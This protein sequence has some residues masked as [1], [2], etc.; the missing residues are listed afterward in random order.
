MGRVNEVNSYSK[1]EQ[2]KGHQKEKKLPKYQ[3]KKPK[4]KKKQRGIPL[5]GKRGKITTAEYNKALQHGDYCLVCQTTIG[6]EAHHVKFKSNSG[7]GKARNVRFL[8]GEH[9]RGKNGP[10]H[11]ETFRRELEALHEKEF[12]PLYWSDEYDLYN[13]N[14]IPNTTKKAYEKYMQSW[15]GV[16]Y[17]L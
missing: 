2:L 15:D 17:E 10:H 5:A 12:G 1:A 8:C 6:I 7:R 16:R 4:K 13:M 9:H 3:V 14:L 11:N